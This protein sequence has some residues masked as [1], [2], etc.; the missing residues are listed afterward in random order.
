LKTPVTNDWWPRFSDQEYER[1]YANVRSAMSERGLDALLIYGGSIYFGT[2]PGAPN[3]VYL[4][5][6]APACHG[7]L[8]LPLE[9]EP[10]LLVYVPGHLKNA[11]EMSLL[12]DVRAGNDLIGNAFRRFSELGTLPERVGYVGN[13]GFARVTIPYEHHRDLTTRMPDTK[14]EDAS[15]WYERDRLVKSEEELV[16]MREGGRM[17][18]HAHILLRERA[19]PGVTDVSLQMAVV[20]DVHQLCGRLPF[21]HV[22]ST[23]MRAP[24]AFYPSFYST[25]RVIQRGDVVLTE[26]AAGP[27]GYFGKIYGTLAIGEPTPA[28]R[29]M[30]ELAS[31]IYQAIYDFAKPGMTISDVDAVLDGGAPVRGFHSLSYISGWSTYNTPPSI[32]SLGDHDQQL[33]ELAPGLCLNIAGWVV[34]SERRGGVW[35][36]DT[37]VVTEHRLESLHSYPVADLEHVILE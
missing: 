33:I 3:L 34:D 14:F 13:F 6:Y 15:A 35:L 9:E 29:T 1:R 24:E 16:Q 8:L 37:A 26:L 31:D 32:K 18:D 25:N 2:D 19:R 20:D 28:Y 21:S 27:G 7:Y 4:T 23:S 11:M 17:T 36:G 30:F 12:E 22:G 5:G 10:T